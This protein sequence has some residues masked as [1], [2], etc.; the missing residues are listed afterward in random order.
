MIAE[1][2]TP[3]SR[4]A[5][6][7]P[8]QDESLDAVQHREVEQLESAVATEVD[9]ALVEGDARATDTRDMVDLVFGCGSFALGPFYGGVVKH[10]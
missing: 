10:T 1:E 3:S 2:V 9:K 7:V 5:H 6:V 8:A 4:C